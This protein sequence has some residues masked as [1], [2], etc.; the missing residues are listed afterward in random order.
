MNVLLVAV[1]HM[2]NAHST[3]LFYSNA[4]LQENCA[5]LLYTYWLLPYF[6]TAK[7]ECACDHKAFIVFAAS[8]VTTTHSR[9][10][11]LYQLVFGSRPPCVRVSLWAYLQVKK[12][13]KY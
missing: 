10:S 13:T 4:I 6:G 5:G 3:R 9:N 8:N 7:R 1:A 2:P 12:S 11:L